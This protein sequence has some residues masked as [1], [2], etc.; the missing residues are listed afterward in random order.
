M[1]CS[2]NAATENSRLR[3]SSSN[4][5]IAV[6]IYKQNNDLIY[7]ICTRCLLFFSYRLL[8]CFHHC[9]ASVATWWAFGFRCSMR[10]IFAC[11]WY[12]YHWPLEWA[13]SHKIGMFLCLV[14]F[15]HCTRDVRSCTLPI[16]FC[17]FF[18]RL[19]ILSVANPHSVF[20]AINWSSSECV[21]VKN[22]ILCT[23][24]VCCV[25]WTQLLTE[26][27]PKCILNMLL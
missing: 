9:S 6:H 25:L 21:N 18:W 11:F 1:Y 20:L 7:Y 16:S 17:G 27:F 24:S 19:N 3:S 12:E 5:S 2:C 15:T 26:C 13:H 22:W 14:Y 23:S 8:N 10:S 4:Y